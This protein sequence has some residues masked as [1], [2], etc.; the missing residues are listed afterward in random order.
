MNIPDNLKYTKDHE[1]VLVEGK[2]AT[3]GVTDYAQEQLGDVVYVEVPQVGEEFNKGDTFGVLESVKAV[4]DCLVPVSGKVLEANDVLGESPETVNDDCYGEAWM[5]R[6]ELSDPKELADLM[7]P[8][9]YEAFVK[10]ES[11]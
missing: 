2:K 4:S 1:W 3:I 5:I 9:E 6:M 11:T 8:S 7:D 10:E